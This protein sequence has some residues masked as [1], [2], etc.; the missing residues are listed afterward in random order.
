MDFSFSDKL[1]PEDEITIGRFLSI[2]EQLA[3]GA[4]TGVFDSY[5][6]NRMIG[7]HLLQMYSQLLPYIEHSRVQRGS[8]TL[9]REYESLRNEIQAMRTPVD[10][11]GNIRNS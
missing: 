6:I 1:K 10:E 3:T 8:D 9:Y 2:V 11:R 5:I 7:T 4:Q